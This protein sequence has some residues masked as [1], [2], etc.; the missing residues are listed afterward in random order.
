[1]KLILTLTK[2]NLHY[3]YKE[4]ILSIISI[5][6]SM[7]IPALLVLFSK[8]LFLKESEEKLKQFRKETNNV[9]EMILFDTE[10]TLEQ[11]DSNIFYMKELRERF[12]NKSFGYFIAL[13]EEAFEP[14]L[15]NLDLICNSDENSTL[16]NNCTAI[17]RPSSADEMLLVLPYFDEELP[18]IKSLD[19]Q[20][21]QDIADQDIL[22]EIEL[23]EIF[24]FQFK[25]KGRYIPYLL[26][27]ITR[28][29]SKFGQKSNLD[30]DKIKLFLHNI[31]VLE[32][33]KFYSDI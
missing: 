11:E 20:I 5:L 18:Q 30:Y 1:M 14:F 8:R 15:E 33:T 12:R 25:Q 16:Y 31:T 28:S 9:D 21:Y 6:L 13:G 23:S 2:V 29:L 3:F 4:K 19:L 17:E 27:F 10:S 22:Q 24:N 7:F 32:T 26:L